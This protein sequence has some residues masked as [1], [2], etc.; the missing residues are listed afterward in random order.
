[1]CGGHSRAARHAHQ[2]GRGAQAILS[3][4]SHDRCHLFGHNLQ[5]AS[6]IGIDSFQADRGP[7]RSYVTTPLRALFD[8]DKIH[9]GGFYHDGR[10]ATR[11]MSWNTT[12]ES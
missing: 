4:S 6:E 11:R 8:T 2:S 5:K 10:F 3:K 12:I 7:E 9:K 1:M